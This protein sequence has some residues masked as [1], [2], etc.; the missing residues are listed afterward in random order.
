MQLKYGARTHPGRR[1][2]ENEDSF[3]VDFESDAYPATPGLF[4]VCDGV[5][6]ALAGKTASALGVREMRAAFRRSGSTDLSQRLMEAAERASSAIF[7]RSQRDAATA[8]MATTL[9]AAAFD[10]ESCYIANVGDSRAY[11][12]AAGEIDRL[13]TDHTLIQEQLE[14]GMIT[15]DQ[16]AISPYRHMITRS[17]GMEPSDFGVQAYPAIPLS[18]GDVYL[19]CSDGLTDMVSEEEILRLGSADDP[20]H[21]AEALVDLAN[22][23]GGRDNVTVLVVRVADGR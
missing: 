19:L 1:R 9:V 22:Q 3:D 16:A 7:E 6:G 21:A 8:G 23:Q 18:V 12:L 17:L 13:T 15:E 4:V 20:Q 5:G 10:A 14:S 2:R 11:R